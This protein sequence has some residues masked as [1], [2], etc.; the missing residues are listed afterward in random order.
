MDIRSAVPCCS[1]FATGENISASNRNACPAAP[2]ITATRRDPI[3]NPVLYLQHDHSHSRWRSPE[4]ARRGGGTARTFPGAGVAER[5]AVPRAAAPRPAGPVPPRGRDQPLELG[6]GGEGAGDLHGEGLQPAP[7]PVVHHP[8]AGPAAPEHAPLPSPA[9]GEE[10]R[11]TR[12]GR[13]VGGAG[14]EVRRRR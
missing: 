2:R 10:R 12:G 8:H 7:V 3:K 13:G 5:D 11:P 6:D 4:P 9:A 14:G 1:A